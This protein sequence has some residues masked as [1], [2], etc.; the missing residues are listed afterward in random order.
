M[1]LLFTS[2]S[3]LSCQMPIRD[4][5]VRKL[6]WTDLEPSCG[7]LNN[8]LKPGEQSWKN[9]RV[10]EK[11]DHQN[12]ISPVSSSGSPPHPLTPD[13]PHLL[14]I[15]PRWLFL[16][17]YRSRKHRK[18]S[19]ATSRKSHTRTHACIQTDRQ[20]DLNFLMPCHPQDWMIFKWCAP[21]KDIFSFK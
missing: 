13:R 12:P 15:A 5:S 1:V 18:P 20:T 16:T 6:T 17:G 14:P 10:N 2:D 9:S 11:H 21:E 19:G 8:D 3:I 4:R 7:L